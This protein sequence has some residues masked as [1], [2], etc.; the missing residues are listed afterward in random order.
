MYLVSQTAD[1]NPFRGAHSIKRTRPKC[2][3]QNI[4]SYKHIII[5]KEGKGMNL[6]SVAHHTK[7]IYF[8]FSF[9]HFVSYLLLLWVTVLPLIRFWKSRGGAATPPRGLHQVAGGGGGRGQNITPWGLTFKFWC[10]NMFCKNKCQ[11]ISPDPTSFA[12]KL[13]KM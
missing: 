10:E 7:E 2:C 5:K 6:H 13:K 4:F 12:S 8:L 11:K 1:L 3:H 9:F